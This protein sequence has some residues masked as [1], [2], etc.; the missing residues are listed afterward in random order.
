MQQ[1][2]AL[3]VL[4]TGANVFLTGEAGSGKTYVLNQ[5]RDWLQDQGLTVAVTASTGIAA[6]HLGGRTIHSWS[7][8]GIKDTLSDRDLERI[9][10]NDQLVDRVRGTDVLILDEVSMLSHRQLDSINDVLKQVRENP[11][12]FGGIQLVLSGDFFQLPPIGKE[13]RLVPVAKVWSAASFAVCYLSSQ[14]RSHND[15]NLS[16]LLSALRIGEFEQQHFEWLQER[17]VIGPESGEERLSVPEQIT[18]LYTHNEDVDRINKQQLKRLPASKKIYTATHIGSAKLAETLVKSSLI[19]HK[20]VLKPD[21]EVM[22][23]KNDPEGQYVNGTRGRVVSTGSAGPKIELSSGKTINAKPVI[24]GI[25]STADGG[26]QASVKQ[27]PLRLAWAVTVHKS[28]GMTL[29]EA[30]LDLSRVFTPG[31]GYVALSRLRS[32]EGL[33]LLGISNQ[34]LAIN[35]DIHQLDQELRRQSEAISQYLAT[36]SDQQLADKQ[37]K[38]VRSRGGTIQSTK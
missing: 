9:Q 35:P 20:L 18:R 5:Y 21:A 38:F 34:A 33:Y 22:F 15:S 2:E 29:E 8:I 4:K 24:W 17:L 16:E 37:D 10:D 11:R 23:I 3:E 31:Q 6:T 27:I 26:T 28:Q 14:Y 12:P 19:E 32:L 1:S 7:G 13:S 30:A 25:E 36:H